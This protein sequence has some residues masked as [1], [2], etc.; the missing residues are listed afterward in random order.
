MVSDQ[1]E[2]GRTHGNSRSILGRRTLLRSILLGMVGVAGKSLVP[3]ASANAET[4]K[5][6]RASAEPGCAPM[7][8]AWRSGFDG[9]SRADLGDGRFVNPIMSGDRPDPT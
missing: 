3:L 4:K 8:P 7:W 9:Q 1:L 5:N 2:F 6:L